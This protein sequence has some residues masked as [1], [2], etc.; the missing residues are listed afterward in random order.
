[1]DGSL[2][3]GGHL[4]T[5]GPYSLSADTPPLTGSIQVAT[6]GG[7]LNRGHLTL[8]LANGDQLIIIPRRVEHSAGK[9]AILM[10]EIEPPAAG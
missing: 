3:D 10:F 9:V 1:M 7:L 2:Y 8:R 5:T 6:V 4:L